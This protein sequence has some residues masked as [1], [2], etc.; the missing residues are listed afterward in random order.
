MSTPA[1][2]LILW[3]WS[4]A[5]G[6]LQALL[7]L[8]N[9]ASRMRALSWEK[10]REQ[11]VTD[12]EVSL[13]SYGVTQAE[14]LAACGLPNAEAVVRGVATGFSGQQGEP[15]EFF[16]MENDVPENAF[17]NVANN[18]QEEEDASMREF[19]YLLELVEHLWFEVA[20]EK[21]SSQDLMW[22][23]RMSRKYNGQAVVL[24]G[25]PVV[26]GFTAGDAGE[27][28]VDERRGGFFNGRWF[29]VKWEEVKS[30]KVWN[31]GPLRDEASSN[32]NY[33]ELFEKCLKFG[34]FYWMVKDWVG[35]EK[36]LLIGW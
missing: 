35:L 12:V 6:K 32:I 27:E 5:K 26:V 31:F 3:T 15:G 19:D 13:D 1:D 9:V 2:H 11:M 25:R 4:V 24:D 28:T 23:A 33:L 7:K 22:P 8:P 14:H 10:Q 36:C 20:L 18:L 30:W 34:P 17:D 29:A 16:T 21:D